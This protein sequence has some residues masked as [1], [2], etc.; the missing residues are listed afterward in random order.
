MRASFAPS[1][2]EP[3]PSSAWL[4]ASERFDGLSES[5]GQREEVWA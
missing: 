4:E 2:Y 3:S 1:V 5:N